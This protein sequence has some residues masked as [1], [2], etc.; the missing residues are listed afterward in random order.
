MN[1]KT[2]KQYGLEYIDEMAKDRSLAQQEAQVLISGAKKT[3]LDPSGH[4]TLKKVEKFTDYV[5]EQVSHLLDAELNR[6]TIK[7]LGRL[8]SI[9]TQEEKFIHPESESAISSDDVITFQNEVKKLIDEKS[10]IVKEKNDEIRELQ[11][12]INTK[13]SSSK[14]TDNVIKSKEDEI[15]KLNSD[16]LKFK[17]ENDL[18]KRLYE[19]TSNQLSNYEK[20]MNKFKEESKIKDD[21]FIV[22]LEEMYQ[23]N[24]DTQRELVD[25]EINQATEALKREHLLKI[26]SMESQITQ[27]Q[28]KISDITKK[29]ENEIKL[30]KEELELAKAE[31]KTRSSARIIYGVEAPHTT[32]LILNYTQRILSTHPLYAAMLILINLGGSMPMSSLA[33]SVGANPLRLKEFISE[34]ETKGL[35][36]IS[37]DNPPIVEIVNF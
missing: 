12:E 2:L 29:Y 30:L 25:E 24:E 31:V 1:S 13:K 21:D 6:I 16:I 17:E 36:T 8:R 23:S 28:D 3:Y 4:Y 32:A 10:K 33:K 19:K 37:D 14:E 22:A 27:E 35:V 34:L 11:N 26:E 20:V 5:Q 9:I 15:K 7:S 18:Y